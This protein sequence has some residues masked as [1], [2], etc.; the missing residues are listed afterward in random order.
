MSAP[1]AKETKRARCILG[2][3]VPTQTKTLL[4]TRPPSLSRTR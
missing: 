3:S 1:K 2:A 4:S